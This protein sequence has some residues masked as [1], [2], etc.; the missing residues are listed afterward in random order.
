[1]RE[2]N[3]NFITGTK[4]CGVRIMVT[5]GALGECVRSV[6]AKAVKANIGPTLQR[7]VNITSYRGA[8]N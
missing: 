4:A 3:R 5:T 8:E 6:I 7:P 2:G 1:V